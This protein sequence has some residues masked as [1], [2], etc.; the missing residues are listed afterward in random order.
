MKRSHL[1]LILAGLLVVTA[2]AAAAVMV[3]LVL[4]VPSA[5][6]GAI[7]GRELMPLVQM[8]VGTLWRVLLA[9]VGY[10]VRL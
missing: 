1:L 10:A 8:V 2:T 9:V 5:V 7:D 6:A 3:W 4:T